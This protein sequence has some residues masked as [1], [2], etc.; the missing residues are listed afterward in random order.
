MSG[1]LRIDLNMLRD[2]GEGL[3][4]VAV[5][6]DEAN[7]N[8]ETIADAVGHDGLADAI[9]SFAKDW[10]DTRAAMVNDIVIASNSAVGIADG[11]DGKDKEL[12]SAFDRPA[13]SGQHGLVQ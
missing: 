13:A 8:S 5:E 3:A 4:R 12:A 2:V 10:D 9:R 11:F 7:T 1:Q 6:F